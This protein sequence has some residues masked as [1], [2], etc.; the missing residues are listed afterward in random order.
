MMAEEGAQNAGRE[1]FVNR[2]SK[3]G[4]SFP[5]AYPEKSLLPPPPEKESYQKVE[6]TTCA[7]M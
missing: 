5:N 6:I 4:S 2:G 3:K 1:H 7:S